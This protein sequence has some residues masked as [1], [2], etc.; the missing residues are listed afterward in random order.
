M[1][2]FPA[3]PS[4]REIWPAPK[5]AVGGNGKLSKGLLLDCIVRIAQMLTA[6]MHD[7]THISVTDGP[8]DRIGVM[9][10]VV[11]LCN[12]FGADLPARGTLQP[13]KTMRMYYKD[14]RM[15][16]ARETITC[17]Y[18]LAEAPIVELITEEEASRAWRSPYR[19]RYE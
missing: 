19:L 5:G 12:A 4:R 17:G 8:I 16:K 6:I 10:L 15:Q 3:V 9:A 14:G 11:Q 1:S 18:S 2:M 13:F 7:V